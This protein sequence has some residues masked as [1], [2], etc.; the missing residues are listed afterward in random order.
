MRQHDVFDAGDGRD[1][2]KQSFQINGEPLHLTVSGEFVLRLDVSDVATVRGVFA[3]G[4]FD[5]FSNSTSKSSVELA[6]MRPLP[7]S[8]DP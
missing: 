4:Y 2:L 5:T 6:G 8:R 3:N 7:T 1:R